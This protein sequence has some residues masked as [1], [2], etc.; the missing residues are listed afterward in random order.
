MTLTASQGELVEI[1]FPVFDIDG[2]TPLTGYVDGDFSKLL[3]VDS[4]VS[5]VVMTV[6]EVGSTGRYVMTF[7]PNADGLW[8]AEVITPIE[9]IFADQV[10]VGPPP[11]DWIDAIA[12]EV[13]VTALPG[14][15][16]VG[17][18]G[19]ILGNVDGTLA[20]ID[21]KIDVI[22]ANVDIMLE[23]LIMGIY[24]ASGGTDTYVET[25]ATKVDGFYDGL[26]AVV[27]GA[28]G[29]VSRRISSYELAD[30][31]FFFDDEL[32]FTPAAG[33][34]VIVLS[35]L[36]KVLCESSSGIL[37]KLIEVWQRLGL[38][39][40]NPLCIKKTE[41]TSN[42]WKLTHSTVGDKIIV[43]RSDV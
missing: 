22:D 13:W 23:A 9:D 11:D 21:G 6:T 19:Y 15:F 4:A 25:D 1:Q 18:A 2:I 39:P 29:N 33:D 40:D 30:G 20:I 35:L 27:R 41:H 38:D 34:E 10:E 17:S 28:D 32:P 36:G 12:Q 16:P 43:Q 42:G 31:T 24:T 7:T 5:A 26:V 37:D 8:Y 14:T 3:L